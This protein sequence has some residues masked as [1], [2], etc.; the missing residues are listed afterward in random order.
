MTI[1]FIADTHGDLAFHPE[2]LDKLLQYDLCILLGDH[3]TKELEI[4]K[5]KIDLK[6]LFGVLGNHDLKDQYTKARIRDLTGATLMVNGLKIG[7]IGGSFKYKDSPYYALLTHNESMRIAERLNGIDILVSHDKPY[8]A[9]TI[10]TA[11]DG[12][13]GI[14]HAIYKNNAQL[15]FHGHLHKP[16]I[17]TLRNGC[18]S[19]CIYGIESIQIK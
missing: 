15:H 8:I 14:T 2:W 1:L 7:G 6:K 4:I 12:L 13:K 19:R 9:D 5:N 17:V 11:H 3:S 18:K 10:D 16:N